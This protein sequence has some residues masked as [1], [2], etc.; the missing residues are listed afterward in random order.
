[1]NKGTWL[2]CLCVWVAGCKNG[3]NEPKVT[4]R[5]YAQSQVDLGRKVYAEYGIGCHRENT[6]GTASWRELT[7][8]GYYPPPPLNGTAH[9][10]HHPLGVLKR[11]IDEGGVPLGGKMPGL[12]G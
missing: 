4:G 10:W 3:S 2:L 1:M 7:P 8:D 6:Q 9:A 5:W 11:T 12:R